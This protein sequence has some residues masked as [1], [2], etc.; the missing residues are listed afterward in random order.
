MGQA[1]TGT[2]PLEVLTPPRAL[3]EL[4]GQISKLAPTTFVDD[5]LC[6]TASSHFDDPRQRPHV[7]SGREEACFRCGFLVW[8][9][10]PCSM[11][12]PRVIQPLQ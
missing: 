2:I 3:E 7:G 9:C 5:A 12:G 6:V 8:C 1:I 11:N 4:S 10:P